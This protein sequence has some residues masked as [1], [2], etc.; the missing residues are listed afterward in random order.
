MATKMLLTLK[1]GNPKNQALFSPSIF[2][3]TPW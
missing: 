3:Y 2:S 1:L